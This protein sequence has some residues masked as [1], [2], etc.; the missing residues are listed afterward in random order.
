MLRLKFLR[1]ARGLRQHQVAELT[2]IP[3]PHYSQIENGIRNPR[4]AQLA[5]LARVFQCSESA[6][7][8]VVVEVAR[9]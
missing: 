5:E 8:E 1:L 6:L 4:P 9:A 3:R 7:L 2:G